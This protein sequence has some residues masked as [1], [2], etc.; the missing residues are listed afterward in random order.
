MHKIYEDN[1]DRVPL[2]LLRYNWVLENIFT[3]PRAAY[4][5]VKRL[6]D[7]SISLV[8]TILSFIIYPLVYLAIKLD[9][10]G[11]VFIAQERVGE[12]NK[13]VKILKFRSMSRDDRGEYG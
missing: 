1:F 9:D 10:G 8:L 3:S 12:G 13:V 6:M 2:S 11:P 4:D 7:V 5:A